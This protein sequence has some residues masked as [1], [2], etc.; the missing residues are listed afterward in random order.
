[1][2]QSWQ[3]SGAALPI[4]L[5]LGETDATAECPTCT[6]IG[7][8]EPGRISLKVKPDGTGGTTPAMCSRGHMVMVQ[9][10]RATE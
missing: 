7:A 8:S 10:T 3:H 4:T 5:A 2:S 1:M 9:W 6:K